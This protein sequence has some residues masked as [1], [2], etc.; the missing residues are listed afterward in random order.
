MP[1]ESVLVIFDARSRFGRST[2]PEEEWGTARSLVV[3]FCRKKNQNGWLTDTFFGCERD[4]EISW[5]DGG[6][7]T[8]VKRDKVI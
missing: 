4:K 1:V 2:I 5:I 7:F 6:A 8:A 3:L